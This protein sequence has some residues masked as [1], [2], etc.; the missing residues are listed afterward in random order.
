[1]DNKWETACKEFLKGCSCAGMDKQEDCEACLGAFCDH[2]RSLA[3]KEGYGDA[4]KKWAS[5]S[6][7]KVS[8]VRDNNGDVCELIGPE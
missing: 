8:H 3:E 5:R 1:M 7:C 4:N 6:A 2:L